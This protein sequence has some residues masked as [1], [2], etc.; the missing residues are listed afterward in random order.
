M[1]SIRFLSESEIRERNLV[2][3]W[4]EQSELAFGEITIGQFREVFASPLL[5]WKR[6]QYERQWN[7][8]LRRFLNEKQDSYLVASLVPPSTEGPVS[9]WRLYSFPDCVKIQ[10]N[11]L[12]CDDICYPVNECESSFPKQDYCK[13]N[14]TGDKVSEWVLLRTDLLL[15]LRSHS[16][17]GELPRL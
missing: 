6:E 2:S 7:Y 5:Y 17:M 11:I 16:G 14:E 1:F 8:A 13:I 4:Y 12:F 15:F 3:S 9:L 10:N